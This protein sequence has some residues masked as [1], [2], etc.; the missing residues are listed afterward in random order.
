MRVTYRFQMR[1]VF[2]FLLC[3]H[4]VFLGTAQAGVHFSLG[5]SV[6]DSHAGYQEQQAVSGNAGLAIDL[7][8]YV[9]VGYTHR[10]DY[11]LV[12][13]YKQY[14]EKKGT[15]D[16]FKTFE[17]KSHVVTHSFDLTLI[18]YAGQVVTPFVFGGVSL[19]L[20]DIDNKE[21]GKDDEHI[22]LPVPGPSGGVGLSISASR[23]FSLTLRH[24]LSRGVKQLP[25]EEAEST[26][27]S[28]T[29]LGISYAL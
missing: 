7:A 9:R 23:Q 26:I 12:K 2:N 17:S 4:A 16:E 14:E 25:G 19:K 5:G 21:E 24:T 13:G 22:E 1:N 27:D 11:A 18:L 6:S 10:Q 15:V 28:Y 3:L 20:Y 29:T 8:D